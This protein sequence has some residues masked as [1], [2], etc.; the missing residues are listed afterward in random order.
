M[1]S[2]ITGE[3]MSWGRS[4]WLASP[5]WKRQRPKNWPPSWAECILLSFLY[6][7]VIK[8]LLQLVSKERKKERKKEKILMLGKIEGRRRRGRQRTRWLDGISDSMDV[9]LRKLWEMVKDREA[10][11]AAVHGVTKS[12]T[13]LSNGTTATIFSSAQSLSR[14]RL[15]VTPWTTACQAS[16][17]ITN[18]GNLLK[19]LSIEL[20]M[21]SNHVILCHPLLLLPLNYINLSLNKLFMICLPN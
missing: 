18:S 8:K 3:A 17:S 12:W 15:F 16:L 2:V 14:V 9:S 20:V 7:K 19:L 21:P 13:R 5:S 11:R 6:I 10:W 4:Q 1:T